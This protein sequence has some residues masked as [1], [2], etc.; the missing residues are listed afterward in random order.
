MTGTNATTEQIEQWLAEK[1]ALS[2][3]LEN[4]E[5]TSDDRKMRLIY[6]K[7]LCDSK[8]IRRFFIAPFFEI[9]SMDLYVQY[10]S[11]LPSGMEFTN[12]VRALDLILSGSVA[13]FVDGKIYLLEALQDVK[14]S[15]GDATVEAIVQGPQDAFTESIFTNL[16]LVRRRYKSSNLKIENSTVGYLSQTAIAL[17]YDD[18]KVDMGILKD[19]KDKFSQLKI[20]KIQSSGELEKALSPQGFRL[21]PTMMTTERP[22]R[23][24]DNLS[25]GKIIILIDTSPFVLILPS[26]FF[27]FFTAMD[28]KVQLPFVGYFLLVLRYVGLFMTLTLPALYVAFTSYNPEILKMNLT[29][30][31]AGSRASV[32]YPSFVEVLIMLV[33]MEF[34]IEASLR[35]PK[36]IGPTAT[37]VGGLILGTASTEAGLVGSIMIILV[38]A[39]AISNFVIPIN[40]MSFSV[41]FAK[42]WFVLLAAVFGLLGVVVGVIGSIIYLCNLRSFGRPYMRLFPIR[43]QR[44]GGTDGHQ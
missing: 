41:R 38:A 34:L 26:T 4:C 27:D 35:L 18:R 44:R 37:T 1:L 2:A 17:V 13:L 20:D 12:V 7:S 6:M 15:V 23:A 43:E 40:M 29:L 22:D 30:L 11:S 16:N 3:D 25:E 8:M 32:P 33:M 42:Y 28:D 39:V 14:S 9:R 19:V 31:I 5:L 10:I 21:V 24:I 36:A